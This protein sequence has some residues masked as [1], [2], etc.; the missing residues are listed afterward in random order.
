MA[1]G[2]AG[3]Q[4]AC[5]PPPP[6]RFLP[7]NDPFL[8]RA[9]PSAPHEARRP[10]AHP[11]LSSRSPTLAP[12]PPCTPARRSS[13]ASFLGGAADMATTLT[14]V[15][16]LTLD[17]GKPP[18]RP[19][20]WQPCRRRGLPRA[21]KPRPRES[22]PLAEPHA[23]S[24]GRKLLR[25]ARRVPGRPAGSTC[26]CPLELPPESRARPWP[27][28]EAGA[29]A[30]G[31]K[32]SEDLRRRGWPRRGELPNTARAALCGRLP[33]RA[34]PGSGCWGGG[35]EVARGQRALW[36]SGRGALEPCRCGGERLAGPHVAG[37]G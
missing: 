2:Q 30:R 17:R 24:R 33:R 10:P 18:A 31:A 5:L 35:M 22:S 27:E 21:L 36:G 4:P 13:R 37:S 28:G 34:P 26:G 12:R 16:P 32:P 3:G 25:A 23:G 20:P 19:L 7:G 8:A 14:A 29:N 6:R 1:R 11:T 15:Q 9:R